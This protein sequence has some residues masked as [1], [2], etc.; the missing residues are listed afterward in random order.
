MGIG[1][2]LGNA[3]KVLRTLKYAQIILMKPWAHVP[4]CLYTVK[5]N[6]GKD[7]NYGKRIGYTGR[8]AWHIPSVQ[9]PAP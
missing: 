4:P 1:G 7:A 5:K 2:L 3:E 8:T 6:P 9:S